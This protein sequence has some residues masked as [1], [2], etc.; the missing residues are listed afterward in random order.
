MVPPH[1]PAVDVADLEVQ[2]MSRS[3]L[4]WAVAEEGKTKR[5][6]EPKLEETQEIEDEVGEGDEEDAQKPELGDSLI[7]LTPEAVEVEDT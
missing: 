1:G 6:W 5:Q 2:D 3:R 4:S 7:S